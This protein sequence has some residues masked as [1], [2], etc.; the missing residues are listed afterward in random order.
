MRQKMPAGG[1][2]P[3]AGY[4]MLKQTHTED[5][6]QGRSFQSQNPS[7]NKFQAISTTENGRNEVSLLPLVL[8]CRSAECIPASG[9]FVP[10][11]KKSL[12]EGSLLI[13]KGV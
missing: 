2:H 3:A 8:F 5:I 4:I 10:G 6:L 12:R 1:L 9:S 13:E 7:G 11:F